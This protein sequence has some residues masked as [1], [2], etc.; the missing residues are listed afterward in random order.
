MEKYFERLIE[1]CDIAYK[2]NEVPV[3]ALIV[4]DGTIIS[5]S[6]NSRVINNSV[7]NHAEIDAINKAEKK[8]GDWRLDECDLYVTLKPCSM[9]ESI[10]KASRIKNV[11]Y[12]IDKLDFKK[13]FNGTSFQQIENKKYSLIIKEKMSNFFTE[14]RGNK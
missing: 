10:I 13:E 8:I 9:C 11:Y 12:L 3:A 6:F 2:K 7:L 14:K 5:E 4:K 1:L